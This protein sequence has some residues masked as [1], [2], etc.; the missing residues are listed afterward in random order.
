[1]WEPCYCGGWLL[2]KFTAKKQTMGRA[3]TYKKPQ[4]QLVNCYKERK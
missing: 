4:W 3:Y 1:M 2:W